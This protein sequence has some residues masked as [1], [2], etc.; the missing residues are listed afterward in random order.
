M[1]EYDLL[2]KKNISRFQA[3]I[4]ILFLYFIIY[5]CNMTTTVHTQE[6][7]GNTWMEII[8]DFTYIY[9]IYIDVYDCEFFYNK[10]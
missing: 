10:H 3:Y 7:M 9:N 2:L 8:S 4:S 6:D 5:L 1:I